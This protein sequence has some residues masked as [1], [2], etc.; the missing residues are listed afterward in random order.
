MTSGALIR[1]ARLRARLSQAELSERSGKDRAQ[2]A[3]WERDVV[4]PSLET[5]RE[6][7][8]AC[9]FDLE[10]RLVSF[11]PFDARTESRL[12][13]ELERTPQERLVAMLERRRRQR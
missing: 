9:G 13:K 2:I 7:L 3:R 6:V 5:L 1:Q 10:L 12:R 8:Q 4:T 11:E